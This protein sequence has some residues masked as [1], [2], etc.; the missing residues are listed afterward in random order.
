MRYFYFSLVLALPLALP[1]ICHAN[2]S[3]PNPQIET[4]L[5]A[6]TPQQIKAY[7]DQLVGFGTRSTLSDTVSAQRGIGAARRWIA[8]EMEKCA[9]TSQGRMTVNLDEHIEPVGAR[10]STPTNIV[11]VVATLKGSAP[12]ER[13]IVVSAH[14][15]SRATDV[16]DAL[17]AAPGANDDASGTAAVIAMACAFAPYQWPATLV[18]MAVAGEEQGLLGAEHWAETAAREHRNIIAMLDDDIIGSPQG[19]HGQ[20]DDMQVRLFADGFTPLLKTV[21]DGVDHH[22]VPAQIRSAEA[23]RKM[24]DMIVRSGGV[25]DTPTHQLGRYLKAAAESYLPGF[26]V[27]LINRRD[28]FLRGGDH[29]SFLERGYPA[30]RYTEPFENFAHQHQN[31]RVDHGVNIGDLTEFV[32]VAYV[33]RVAQANA[34]G[35]ASLALAPAAPSDVGLKVS[36]LSND[37][38]LVWKA[39]PDPLVVGYRLLWR[40]PGAA[41]WQHSRDVGQVNDYTLQDIS[42]DNYVFGVAAIGK[43]GEASLPIFPQPVK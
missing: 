37:S 25:E 2:P 43:S 13:V 17:S 10:V 5:S 33:A 39:S 23:S 19:D 36:E 29:L 6:I 14:Y 41:V 22:P 15:D 28:R 9:V 20:R 38:R 34:A 3:T 21:L 30:V 26:H 31:V 8:G 35:M 11:N 1:L 32:D 12:V 18:F 4:I 7:D 27:N 16:M 40:E 42:K 24:I